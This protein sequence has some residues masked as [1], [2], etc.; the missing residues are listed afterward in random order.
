MYWNSGEQSFGGRQ[1]NTLA[2]NG[3]NQKA[4]K[5]CKANVT[6]NGTGTDIS[7]VEVLD[8]RTKK[9]II[10]QK[11]MLSLIDVAT[12][13]K[14]FDRV[15]CYWNTF[16]CQSRLYGVGNILYGKYCKNRFCDVCSA[17]R[18]A[19]IINK[20]KTTIA[21]WKEPQLVTLTAKTV[22]ANKLNARISNMQ[23]ALRKI[24]DRNKKRHQRGKARKLIG[25]KSLECNFN[26]VEKWYNPHFHLIVPD[27]NTADF[28]VGEWCKLWTREFVNPDGQDIRKINNLDGA[29]IEVIKYGTKVF[30]DPLMRKKPP[31]R[32]SA[33]IYISALNN[34]IWA[35]KGHRIFDRFGFDLP[36]GRT[37]K[38]STTKTLT[39]PDEWLFDSKMANWYNPETSE[40]ISDYSLPPELTLI[41]TQNIDT[42]LQ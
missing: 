10:T 40:L 37:E 42:V 33:F 30:T 1:F 31:N 17:I 3:S 2:Q 15:Q 6:V 20:Y 23:R 7:K 29:L 22:Y 21:K 8:Q 18:K 5:N 4:V 16:H 9:K 28:I 13:K 19:E 34:I 38:E 26:P 32:T 14:Q 41:L 12:S 11:K 39:E 35:L 36:K 27:K 25:I 24:L